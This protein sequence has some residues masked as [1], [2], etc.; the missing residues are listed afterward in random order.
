MFFSY[1]RNSCQ[2]AKPREVGAKREGK[3]PVKKT[4]LHID[5]TYLN[6]VM[7]HG[8]P[9]RTD[10]LQRLL[11]HGPL[12][13]LD[14][15]IRMEA[16]RKATRDELLRVHYPGHVDR[17]ASTSGERHVVLDPDTHTSELSY[18]TAL[19]AVGGVLDLIDE[20]LRGTIENG[21]ALVRPPGHHAGKDRAM[22]FCLFNNVAVGARHLTDDHG[23]ERVLIVDW[24]IHHGN[25]TQ[26]V[27]YDDDRVLF[28]SLHQYPHYPGTGSVHEIGV[29]N[30]EGYTVNIPMTFDSGDAECLSAFRSIIRPIAIQFQPQFVLV[31]AGFDGHRDDPLSNTTVTD[32]GYAGMASVLLDIACRC[33]DSRCVAVLE[34]G[35]NLEALA[36]SVEAVVETMCQVGGDADGADDTDGA[37]RVDEPKSDLMSLIRDTH[38]KYWDI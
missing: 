30:G 6:H 14:G 32:R 5:K 28:M 3:M 10:R 38:S 13:E 2:A 7:P 16:G 25:G 9:E 12:Y 33:A 23:L 29:G 31:S 22:G 36:T 17:I 15:I 1:F 34:G 27:F 35:Y 26:D 19:L 24:D 20:V 21:I 8:H 18:D 11:D 4:G 37:A